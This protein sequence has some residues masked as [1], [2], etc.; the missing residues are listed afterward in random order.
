VRRWSR[1]G[2]RGG[3]ALA[4]VAVLVFSSFG[5]PLVLT[6]Q[7]ATT[8]ASPVVLEGE[9]TA[10]VAAELNAWQDDISADSGGSVTMDYSDG[11]GDAHAR[12]DFVSGNAD[13]VISGVPFQPS[14]L[15]GIKGGASSVISVPLMPSALEFLFNPPDG[16]FFVNK[17]DGSDVTYGP[18]DGN[19]IPYVPGETLDGCP[20]TGCPPFNAPASN[21]A[22]MIEADSGSSSSPLNYWGNPAILA[23]WD[24]TALDY[25][26]AGGDTFNPLSGA[27]VTFLRQEPDAENYYLQEYFSTVAPGQW[28]YPGPITESLPTTLAG[29]EPTALGLKAL[30]GD[31]ES[32]YDPKSGTTP[33]GGTL[34]EAPPS[35]NNLVE[36]DEDANFAQVHSGKAASPSYYA[37]PDDVQLQ[38]A[39][40]DWVSPT[41]GAIE[42]G[43]DAGASAGEN[44]CS[45]TDPNALYAMSNKVAGAYPLSWVDCLYAPATGLSIS[46]TDALAGTIRYLATT[47]QSYLEPDD[48]G[49]LPAT[50]VTQALDAADALVR[51][52]CP[53]AGGEVVLTSRSTA[54]TTVSPGVSALGAVD[55]CQAPLVPATGSSST[56]AAPPT[57][58][59][60]RSSIT[61]GAG[62]NSFTLPDSAFSVGGTNEFGAADSTA[63]AATDSTGTS[64]AAGSSGSS[65][66]N[67]GA[68]AKR[69]RTLVTASI[70]ANL[71]EP[72]S[73][74]FDAGFDK[75]SALLLGGLLFLGGRK[76]YRGITKGSSQ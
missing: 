72:L 16:G 35:A 43:V 11:D 28:N 74:S 50:Y 47:G 54:W 75:L 29:S 23:T 33:A 30:L 58:L 42:A 73:T 20:S 49:A 25:D 68:G 27:P 76:I 21:L 44:A 14:E 64:A 71:P 8:V 26:P 31:F 59:V 60:P 6:A 2:L 34:A 41:P 32:D 4:G 51:D 46:K 61:S 65:A 36:E 67:G 53:A 39:N 37:V 5:G 7:A 40:G 66:S 18:D 19:T 63:G 62:G 13:Y 55:Q 12:A 69:K 3:A 1:I 45:T 52:N 9:G 17:P 22:A 24:Q 48:D 56:G 10:D 70:A 57:T 15:A 38:N